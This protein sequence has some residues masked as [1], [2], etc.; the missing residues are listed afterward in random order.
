MNS[1]TQNLSLKR[2][3]NL[4][5]MT[6]ISLL[7]MSFFVALASISL[8]DARKTRL[9]MNSI[10]EGFG[11]FPS[12]KE[13][14]RGIPLTEMDRL[15]IIRFRKALQA[16]GI[17]RDTGVYSSS[18]G[19]TL[20]IKGS[21]LFDKDSASLKTDSLEKVNTIAL[22]LKDIPNEI[23]ITGYTDSRP[24]ETVPFSSNWTLSAARAMA[25]MNYLASRGVDYK[26]MR[27]YGMGPEHPISSNSTEAG[28]NINSRVEITI[29]GKI[30][31]QTGAKVKEIRKGETPP[32]PVYHY[33]GYEIPIEEK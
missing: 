26:R 4:V 27:T 3:S 21:L 12:Q 17:I 2:K 9:G 13:G 16:G 7:L 15:D 20:A 10:I 31:G 22:L 32:P 28:R 25:V 18:L 30:P 24:I 33:K 5:I 23:V 11:M 29:A 1:S 19:T 6:S 14:F 8:P